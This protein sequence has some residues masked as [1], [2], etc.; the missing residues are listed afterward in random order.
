MDPLNP[1][2]PL[3]DLTARIPPSPAV[4][5]LSPDEQRQQARDDQHSEHEPDE[6]NSD[7]L[8]EEATTED[9]STDAFFVP[10]VDRTQPKPAL[11]RP[12]DE[13]RAPDD[14]DHDEGT[15]PAHID[16]IA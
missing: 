5:R 11:K 2:V 10:E 1:I 6:E 13:R 15:T 14:D 3:S 12:A 4:P 16:I 7:P 8:R 9:F